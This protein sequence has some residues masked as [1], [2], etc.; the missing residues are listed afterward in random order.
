MK[1]L[2]NIMPQLREYCEAKMKEKDAKAECDK[3]KKVIGPVLADRAGE[4]IEV[5]GGFTLKVDLMPGRTSLDKD[6]L[7]ADGID[8]VQYQKTG[9]PYAQFSV[10]KV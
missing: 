6:A 3:L 8:I 4:T 5:V 2:D 1:S 9:R 10:K 7:E